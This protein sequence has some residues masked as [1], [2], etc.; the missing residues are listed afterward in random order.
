MKK[1]AIATVLA[2]LLL[3]GPL[4]EAKLPPPTPAEQAAAAAKAEKA[5]E[6]AAKEK[7]ALAAAEDRAV[8]NYKKNKGM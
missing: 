4:A 3:G 8:A 7:A 1:T 2:G 6:A 5:K